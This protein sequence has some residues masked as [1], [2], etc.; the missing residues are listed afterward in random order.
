MAYSINAI[1]VS[2]FIETIEEEWL[3]ER[4]ESGDVFDSMLLFLV[5]GREKKQFGPFSQ[6]KEI[7]TLASTFSVVIMPSPNMA[8][9]KQ[10]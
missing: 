3:R 6:I 7:K 10:E 4:K 1:N 9:K 5:S 8:S 2:D